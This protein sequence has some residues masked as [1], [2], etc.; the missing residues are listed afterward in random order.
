MPEAKQE[1]GDIATIRNIFIGF[2]P[3]LN[4]KSVRA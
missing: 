2:Q 4:G 3:H 1:L